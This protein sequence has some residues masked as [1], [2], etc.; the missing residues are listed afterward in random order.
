MTTWH[1]FEVIN[2]FCRL[3]FRDI[4]PILIMTGEPSAMWTFKLQ[5]PCC[6]NGMLCG[7]QPQSWFRSNLSLGLKEMLRLATLKP[8]LTRS[9]TSWEAFWFFKLR[10]ELVIAVVFNGFCWLRPTYLYSVY[11]AVLSAFD[12]IVLHEPSVFMVRTIHDSKYRSFHIKR[13]VDRF[14]SG[15]VRPA[16]LRLLW[17][18]NCKWPSGSEKKRAHT[19][20]T[21]QNIWRMSCTRQ[22]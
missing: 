22:P 14:L 3:G 11:I 17:C 7:L 18:L 4:C 10:V 5:D 21:V 6:C 9:F 12:C 13:G 8:Y 20:Q 1:A 19:K 2:A 15:C 16:H